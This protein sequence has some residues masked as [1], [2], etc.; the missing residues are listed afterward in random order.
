V[1]VAGKA[2]ALKRV[3]LRQEARVA[4]E[5]T[6]I[7]ELLAQERLDKETMVVMVQPLVR[8]HLEGLVVVAQVRLAVTLLHLL[9]VLVAPVIPHLYQVL[10]PFTLAAG[11]VLLITELRL[12]EQVA[13][14]MERTMLQLMPQMEEQI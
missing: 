4:V 5:I 2:V 3:R 10:L 13:V 1:V 6:A 12:V 8:R 9:L 11:V 14:A 7:Q